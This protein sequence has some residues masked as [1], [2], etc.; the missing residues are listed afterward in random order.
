MEAAQLRSLFLDYFAA[1]GHTVVPSAS[2]IP[3]DPT[4]L[5]TVAGM[6]PFKPYFTGEELAPFDRAVSIQ[7]CF[8]A[9][10]IDVIGSD[11]RHLTFFEMMGNFSFGDYFKE[12]AISYAWE[13]VT[14]GFGLD[15]ARL[16][17][18]VHE[19]DDEAADIW[20]N[21]VGLPKER[22]QRMGEENIWAMGDVGP[23]GYDSEIFYDKGDE[24]GAQ[25]GPALG[26]EDRYVEIW[27]L[28]FMQ[29]ERQFDGT[30]I[31]L[32]K[33][34]IDTGAGFERVLSVLNG[35]ESVFATDLFAPLLDASARA[36]K[37]TYGTNEASDILIRRVAEHGRAMTMLVGD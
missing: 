17:V 33:K 20:L 12:G 37:T 5:F 18:T 15:P 13:L 28:V 2:L 22:L 27:N 35:V 16:W 32:P 3:H 23:C 29:F 6:V 7:K 24:F 21:G 1:R 10:D 9:P 34:N 25:G 31:D 4:L 19:D 11:Q 36:L 14:E 26:G 30:M 8:R